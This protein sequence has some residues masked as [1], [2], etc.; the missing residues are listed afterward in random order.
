MKVILTT[1]A[2]SL[3][4]FRQILVVWYYEICDVLGVSDRM[5]P[6]AGLLCH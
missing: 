4:S 5:G 3:I 6:V 1:G 2:V